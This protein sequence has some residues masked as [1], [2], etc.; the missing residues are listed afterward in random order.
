MSLMQMG[1][2]SAIVGVS[3][4]VAAILG[5]IYKPGYNDP[6]WRDVAFFS[7]LGGMIGSRYAIKGFKGKY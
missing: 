6:D 5:I 2:I 1:Y 3:S 4:S 7:A